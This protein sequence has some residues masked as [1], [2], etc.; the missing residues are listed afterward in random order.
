MKDNPWLSK[1]VIA[2][3]HQAGAKESPSSTLFAIQRAVD[4]GCQAIEL[5][6]HATLDRQLVVSHDATVDA[7][8]NGSGKIADMTLSELKKLDFSYWFSTQQDPGN[9]FLRGKFKTDK[10]Y[11]VA[12]LDEIF[13]SFPD[14]IFNFD[15]KQTDPDVKGYEGLLADKIREFK[16]Q[17][18]VIV[19]SFL[20]GAIKKF[21][22]ICPEVST[23]ASANEVYEF[24]QLWK[25]NK[26]VKGFAP[27]ALQVPFYFNGNQVVNASFVDYAHRHNLVVHVWTIDEAD[28]M[29]ELLEFNVDAIMTDCPSVLVSILKEKNC[30]WEP[31]RDRN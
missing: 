5:D 8:S 12:T 24:Y 13:S 22:E 2:Y 11:G 9:Y 15:I 28:Q 30:Y 16:M 27:L 3:A 7:T 19:A 20:D 4:L 14:I 23:S 21:R 31:S 25:N 10:N 26:D 29:N 6:V 1:R 17:D 18:N